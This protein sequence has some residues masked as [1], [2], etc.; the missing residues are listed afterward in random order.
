MEYF[1]KQDREK[2]N[3]YARRKGAQ[4]G[5]MI[6]G[7]SSKGG[8]EKNWRSV[9][10]EKERK[11]ES[12]GKGGEGGFLFQDPFCCGGGGNRGAAST[13]KGKKEA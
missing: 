9:F 2:E 12:L 11:V 7:L 1:S 5:T 8:G 6:L 3:L 4:K 13:D 10:G